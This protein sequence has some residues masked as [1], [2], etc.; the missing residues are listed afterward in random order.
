MASIRQRKIADTIKKELGRVI[1]TEV[2]DPDKGFITVTNTR[3]TPDLSIAYIYISVIGEEG[4]E[5]KSLAVLEKAA[6]FLRTAIARILKTKKA[7]ML[8]FFMDDTLDYMNSMNSIV[9][10]IH[11]D[12]DEK[13]SGNAAAEDAEESGA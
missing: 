7:P 6:G 11:E 8:K 5:E 2:R 10:K 9:K 13:S 3:V 1:S 12:D 4:Q